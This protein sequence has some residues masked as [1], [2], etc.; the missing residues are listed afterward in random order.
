MHLCAATLALFGILSFFLDSSEASTQSK[1]Q[2]VTTWEITLDTSTRARGEGTLS[3]PDLPRTVGVKLEGPKVS[4]QLA[5]VNPPRQVSLRLP[6]G[7]ETRGYLMQS[8]SELTGKLL[9]AE[10]PASP[11]RDHWRN[12][13]ARKSD[14]ASP[15]ANA[16]VDIRTGPATDMGYRR[17]MPTFHV[18]AHNGDHHH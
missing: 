7:S 13:S 5:S 14:W 3:F 1:A 10:K 2:P 6:D 12:R 4:L 15:L 9:T 8:G 17:V 18:E 16:P 11:N